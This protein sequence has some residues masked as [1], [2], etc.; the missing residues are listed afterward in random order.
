MNA[1]LR[2]QPVF[3]RMREADLDEV[4]CIERAV[5]E[6]PWTWGNFSDSL[7]AGY[8]CWVCRYGGRVVG[9]CVMMTGA[10]ETHLLNLSIGSSFQRQGHG[11]R[12]LEHALAVAAGLSSRML[13]LEVR[14]S[15]AAARELYARSGFRQ[16]GMRKDYYP[17]A[18]GREDAL[19]LSVDLA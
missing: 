3:E 9:Y 11:R 12:L 6:F 14:P 18:S 2:T 7:R 5:Y 1:V 17:A 4:L 19:V 8:S 16:I 15:N 13:F 10:S